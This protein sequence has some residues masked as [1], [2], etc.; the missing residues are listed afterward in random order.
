MQP[1]LA[2]AYNR[3]Y[4]FPSLKKLIKDN[5]QVSI[6][7][8]ST[9]TSLYMSNESKNKYIKILIKKYK[10]CTNTIMFIEYAN[11]DIDF[12]L[13]NKDIVL[14]EAFERE[15]L[16]IYNRLQNVTK[17]ILI[18]NIKFLKQKLK[19]KSKFICIT[20]S[21]LYSNGY[22]ASKVEYGILYF[23]KPLNFFSSSKI[24]VNLSNF[25]S[26]IEPDEQAY[27]SL[28]DLTLNIYG[29]IIAIM[30]ILSKSDG[31]VS[32][33]E[34]KYIKNTIA[35]FIEDAKKL[36]F[37][38]EIL[39]YLKNKL[40]EIHKKSKNE[41]DKIEYYAKKINLDQETLLK[42]M[43]K[44]IEISKIEGITEYKKL[45]LLSISKIFGINEVY[46][47][48]RINYEKEK[49][50][51]E[52]SNLNPYEVLGCSPEDNI[53]TIKKKYKTLVMRFHPDNITGKGLDE[54][55]VIFANEKLKII[56]WAYDNIKHNID[57]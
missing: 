40:V 45:K 18:N 43:D 11:C 38:D 51:I 36:S 13:Y 50:K 46:V 41:N 7:K 12:L 2:L 47:R 3:N 42:H 10:V 39:G 1:T 23:K 33:K 4:E 21:I 48:D 34:A 35:I 57:N 22:L 55:F 53:A 25:N 6:V 5:C 56:N 29:S 15:Y 44:F 31:I 37:S 17:D 28:L 32:N 27:G 54:E 49:K 14:G 24:T 19:Q 30:S 52:Y 26:E 16:D 9:S 8:E 20:E